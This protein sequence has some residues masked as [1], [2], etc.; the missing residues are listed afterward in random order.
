MWGWSCGCTLPL[1]CCRLPITY[2]WVKWRRTRAWL[3]SMKNGVRF[4]GWFDNAEKGDV[5]WNCEWMRG[6]S[7]GCTPRQECCRLPPTYFWTTWHQI[8]AL[9]ISMKIEKSDFPAG[10]TI[11]KKEMCHGI[12]SALGLIQ[13]FHSAS[14]RL[15]TTAYLIL[16]NVAPN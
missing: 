7:R 5:S 1:E 11:R 12:V 15:Q 3:I 8:R 2:F 14:I 13:W 9:L 10:L 16:G 6:W 4:S